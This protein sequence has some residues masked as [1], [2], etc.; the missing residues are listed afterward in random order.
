[1]FPLYRGAG[2]RLLRALTAFALDR[3]TPTPTRR[4]GRPR[5]C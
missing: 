1:M 2:A 3:H 5:W 4:S